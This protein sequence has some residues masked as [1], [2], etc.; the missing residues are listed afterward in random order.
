[1]LEWRLKN[2]NGFPVQLVSDS[3]KYWENIKKD[4]IEEWDSLPAQNHLW[5]LTEEGLLIRDTKWTAA[6]K[7]GSIKLLENWSPDIYL[8]SGQ[9][10]W[11]DQESGISRAYGEGNVLHSLAPMS[12]E[13]K[14]NYLILKW[15][16]ENN[17]DVNKC[18][19]KGV[20][21]LHAFAAH[22]HPPGI[23]ALMQSGASLHNKTN[24]GATPT[25]LVFKYGSFES[26][27]KIMSWG[28]WNIDANAKERALKA[29][30]S[31]RLVEPME[32][33]VLTEGMFSE[34]KGDG[35]KSLERWRIMRESVG[36]KVTGLEYRNAEELICGK[37][38]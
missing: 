27:K 29:A 32:M 35:K 15:I 30:L 3:L 25:E 26:M 28:G 9:E 14:V 31:A 5:L 1:M 18:N 11:G 22:G 20:T 36:R 21:P 8:H 34:E 13:P 4:D 10:I 33:Y 23:E 7:T 37:K 12:F 2:Q 16:K 6:A 19:R 38:A 17:L 24:S